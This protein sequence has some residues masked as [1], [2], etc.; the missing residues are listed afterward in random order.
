M[1]MKAY[2]APMI[3]PK[4]EIVYPISLYTAENNETICG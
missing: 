3:A 4:N 2:I 1:S